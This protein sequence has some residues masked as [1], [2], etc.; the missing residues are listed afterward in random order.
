MAPPLEK[1]VNS[2]CFGSSSSWRSS[3]SSCNAVAF[4]RIGLFVGAVLFDSEI[5]VFVDVD[6]IIDEPLAFPKPKDI[7]FDMSDGLF[8]TASY[9]VV[10]CLGCWSEKSKGL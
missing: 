7:G 4:L 9:N 1:P 6:G 10:A 2:S 3:S 8:V 5:D